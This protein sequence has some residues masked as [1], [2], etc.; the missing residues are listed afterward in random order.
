M[1]GF[2][3][4]L[5]PGRREERKVWKWRRWALLFYD[6]SSSRVGEA[7]R[8]DSS[9]GSRRKASPTEWLLNVGLALAPC[10]RNSKGRG[11]DRG[12]ALQIWRRQLFF[13]LLAQ[14]LWCSG[15]RSPSVAARSSQSAPRVRRVVFCSASSGGDRIDQLPQAPG[16]FGRSDRIVLVLYFQHP[17]NGERRMGEH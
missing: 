10:R 7:L 16:V 2:S 8:L 5:R 17:R 13:D 11:T 14:L 15:L 12:P 6:P 9:S 1:D 4:V 3:G